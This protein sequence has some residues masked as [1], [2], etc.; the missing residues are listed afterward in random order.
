MRPGSDTCAAA[1]RAIDNDL[2]SALTLRLMR[3][4]RNPLS[5]LADLLAISVVSLAAGC[6]Q[7][8]ES[9]P[10][11]SPS[12]K[13]G[14]RNPSFI[15]CGECGDND[16]L[17]ND[18]DDDDF[19]GFE[20][21]GESG[22]NSNVR[23]TGH[24]GIEG[25]RGE[26]NEED[27]ETCHC[28]PNHPN[29]C[30]VDLRWRITSGTRRKIIVLETGAQHDGLDSSG[31]LQFSVPRTGRT[32]RLVRQNGNDRTVASVKI[33][34]EPFP[35]GHI[36]EIS[37]ADDTRGRIR[38]WV[39]D[40]GRAET[41]LVVDVFV[42]GEKQ[43]PFWARL[44]RPDVRDALQTAPHDKFGFEFT[45]ANRFFDGGEHNLRVLAKDPDG[46]QDLVLDQSFT[47]QPPP[48]G[49]Q[50]QCS[51]DSPCPDGEQCQ[52]GRC[53]QAP[54][55]AFDPQSCEWAPSFLRFCENAP[56]ITEGFFTVDGQDIFYSNGGG[57]CY[58][59]CWEDSDD[60][61]AACY[62]NRA[63]TSEMPP[64]DR[65]FDCIPASMG[66]GKPCE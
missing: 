65:N 1:A 29:G 3:S 55:P 48:V 62:V 32:F 26:N 40:T 34:P 42:D 49:E 36:D 20:G 57:W 47:L 58:I 53:V 38:G 7:A 17:A 44:P 35:Q 24:I 2:S 19:G 22:S 16:P 46:Q 37:D 33:V 18:D 6:S 14:A 5:L 31:S 50:P 25:C 13:R 12:D 51:D 45:L 28:P 39:A 11:P 30:A 59:A 15:E 54:P 8:P 41:S 21:N 64:A 27:A 43:F 66:C 10:N 9:P 60:P 63:R 56:T 52:S 61:T 4:R 23:A